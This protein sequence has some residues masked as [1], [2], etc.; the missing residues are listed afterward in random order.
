MLHYIS[1]TN[2]TLHKVTL[3]TN[4]VVYWRKYLYIFNLHLFTSCGDERHRLRIMLIKRSTNEET[5]ETSA[6]RP[7]IAYRITQNHLEFR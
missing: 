1:V 4:I 5:S 2:V 6:C 3:V 7:H